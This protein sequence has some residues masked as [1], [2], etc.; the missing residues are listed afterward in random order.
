MPDNNEQHP[1]EDSGTVGDERSEVRAHEPVTPEPERVVAEPVPRTA[2]PSY[3]APPQPRRA[4]LWWGSLLVFAGALL[5]ISQFVPQVQAWRYWPLIIVALGIRQLFGPS[6]GPWKLHHLGEGLTTIAIGAVF[7]GQMTGNL[8]WNVWLNLLRL[9]PLLLVSFGLEIIG[10][11][12]R[13]EFVRLLG[14]LVIAAGIIY[15]AFVMTPTSGFVFPW[16][17]AGES[18]EFSF[19]ADADASV[20]SGD[21]LI[22][23]AVGSLSVEAGNGIA[24]ASGS[25]PFEPLF[26]TDYEGDRLELRVGLGE[27]VWGPADPGSELDVV[28]GEDVEWDLEIEAGVSEYDIDLRD[29]AVRSLVLEAGVSDGTLT[30]GEPVGD[31]AIPV[32][33]DPGVSAL[34]IRV[35]RGVAARVTVDAGLTGVDVEGR[36]TQRRDDDRRVWES[37]DFGDRQGY[38]DIVIDAGVSGINIEY[39]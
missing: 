32:E 9:W 15:G 7:L 36:W 22:E 10:K 29:L 30:L 12:L 39:Y 11:S 8:P 5:L 34:T 33:I 4:A 17:V 19:E 25:T 23:G 14:S 31:E 35:P 1:P 16:G 21:A 6:Q 18:E 20:E 2:E 38:W 27:G 24:S 37:D 28:L 3:A 13:S 26:E